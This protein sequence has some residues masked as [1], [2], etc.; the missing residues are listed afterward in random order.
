MTNSPSPQSTFVNRVEAGRRLVEPLLKY[1]NRDDVII[2]ALPRGGVPVAYE[3]ACALN[4]RLDLMLVRKLGLPS[5]PEFAMGAIAS[6]GVQIM[7]EEALRAHPIDEASFGA[8]LAREK[9]ELLRREQ[10]Y[11][12]NRP[13]L[14]LKDQVV[15]LIDDGVATGTSMLA[16][17]H[18]V[19]T[20]APCRIV[21]AVPVAPLETVEQLRGEVDEMI[22]PLTLQWL[23]SIGYWYADFSQTSDDEVTKLLQRAWQ[24]E[25]FGQPGL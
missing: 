15:I 3:V 18:A 11:R 23:V 19:R 9:Q 16:A 1:A 10:V 12:G 25:T 13:S 7:N 14:Y 4:V 8:V 21:V 20:H 22:C 5:Q 17:I 6:G 2:L 24:K